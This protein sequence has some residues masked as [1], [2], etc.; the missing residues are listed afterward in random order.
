MKEGI[1]VSY[2][3]YYEFLIEGKTISSTKNSRR[4]R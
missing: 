1:L 2:V 3:D 4:K